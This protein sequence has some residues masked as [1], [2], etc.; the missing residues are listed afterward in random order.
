MTDAPDTR[1]HEPMPA[2]LRIGV[3]VRDG[4]LYLDADDVAAM[5]RARAQQYRRRA[6]RL[7]DAAADPATRL[8]ADARDV[9]TVVDEAL[10]CRMVAEELEQRADVIAAIG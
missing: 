8:E 6:D 2:E 3:V 5:L 1:H 9:V 10:A 4:A 7:V